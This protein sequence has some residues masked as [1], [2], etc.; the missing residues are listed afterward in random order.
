MLVP[1]E[2]GLL[3]GRVRTKMW[4][5]KCKEKN[6]YM[7]KLA[8]ARP[9]IYGPGTHITLPQGITATKNQKQQRYAACATS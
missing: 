3:D 4:G 8:A 2:P 1:F 5:K 9:I 7:E 6:I